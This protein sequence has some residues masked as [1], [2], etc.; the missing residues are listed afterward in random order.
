MKPLRL[1]SN[2]NTLKLS[3]KLNYLVNTKQAENYSKAGVLLNKHKKVGKQKLKEIKEKHFQEVQ[4]RLPYKSDDSLD[5]YYS[6][7][8]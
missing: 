8:M 5:L 6:A 7:G 2:W 1:P 3:Q 4:D